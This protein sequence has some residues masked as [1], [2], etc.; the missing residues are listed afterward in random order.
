MKTKFQIKSIFGNLLFE[1]EC[2]TVIEAVIEAVKCGADLYGADLRGANLRGANLYRAKNADLPK[3]KT[4][5]VPEGELIGW[6][7]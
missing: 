6:K 3:A 7:K 2:E 5:I 4:V 1:F